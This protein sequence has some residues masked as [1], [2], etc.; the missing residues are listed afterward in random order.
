MSYQN[1]VDRIMKLYE[2]INPSEKK[3]TSDWKLQLT[4]LHPQG[5][6]LIKNIEEVRNPKHRNRIIRTLQGLFE[7]NPTPLDIQLVLAA[8]LKEKK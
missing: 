5:Y 4:K 1:E 6:E 3:S 8:E 2:L 7:T